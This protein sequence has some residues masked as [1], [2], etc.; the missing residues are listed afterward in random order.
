MVDFLKRIRRVRLGGASRIRLILEIQLSTAF[1]LL[2][3]YWL[4][5]WAGVSNDGP[6]TPF[7]MFALWIVANKFFMSHWTED[8]TEIEFRIW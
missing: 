1:G 8:Q 7:V 3:G 6:E 2:L 4:F 5:N